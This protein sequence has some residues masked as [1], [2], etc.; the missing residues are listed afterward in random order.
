MKTK[1]PRMYSIREKLESMKDFNKNLP[2]PINPE[3]QS[4]LDQ[5]N[6]EMNELK[7]YIDDIINENGIR[8]DEKN[9]KRR[10]KK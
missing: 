3:Q 7:S 8:S 6:K 1:N 5:I 10:T 4:Y 9:I 2:T